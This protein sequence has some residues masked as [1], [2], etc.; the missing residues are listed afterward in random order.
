L[1]AVLGGCYG[2]LFVLLGREEYAL[3]IGS[4]GT[5]AALALTMWLTRRTDWRSPFP[6]AARGA[7]A[8]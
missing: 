2:G 4:L 3:L 1:A 5:F 7:V 8:G 6:A